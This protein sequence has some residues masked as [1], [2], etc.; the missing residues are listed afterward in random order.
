MSC[1]PQI[2]H[3]GQEPQTR[4]HLYVGLDSID[5]C[6]SLFERAAVTVYQLAWA[7]LYSWRRETPSATW[8][9]RLLIISWIVV[10]SLSKILASRWGSI[11]SHT[12]SCVL[13]LCLGPG[14]D[15]R[16]RGRDW[17][18]D[19]SQLLR[20]AWTPWHIPHGTDGKAP[21]H[22]LEEKP[23]AKL[24]RGVGYWHTALLRLQ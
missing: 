9:T 16:E 8:G 19:M 7:T 23:I 4:Y 1:F 22:A 20:G 12:K 2:F 5:T 24:Q 13:H 3:Q 11:T 15:P 17:T 14:N 18:Q 10:G 21:H 6:E